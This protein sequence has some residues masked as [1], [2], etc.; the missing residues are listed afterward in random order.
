MGRKR[1][2]KLRADEQEPDREVVADWGE[3]A[4]NRKALVI[5]RGSGVNPAVVQ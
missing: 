5:A 4:G 3:R 2:A 1:G